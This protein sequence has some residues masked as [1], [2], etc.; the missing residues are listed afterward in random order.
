M[1]EFINNLSAFF[2][3]GS[4][5]QWSIVITVEALALLLLVSRIYYA[6]R[7]YKRIQPK[8]YSATYLLEVMSQ[9]STVPPA[10]AALLLNPHP[11]RVLTTQLEFQATLL[12]LARRGYLNF[13]TD[14]SKGRAGFVINEAK[15]R[16][17]LKTFEK[18]A[19]D[20]LRG[21]SK[22]FAQTGYLDL[23]SFKG[24]LGLHL[25]SF[26]SVWKREP[27]G[28][29]V[30]RFGLPVIRELYKQGQVVG[31]SFVR[32]DSWQ[33]ALRKRNLCRSIGRSFAGLASVASV[34]TWLGPQTINMPSLLA[35]PLTVRVSLV[36]TLSLWGSALFC[37][38]LS[39]LAYKIIPAWQPE[40]VD[41]VWQWRAFRRL[42]A[43]PQGLAKEL[44]GVLERR[45]KLAI[46]ALALGVLPA[47]LRG[48][49]RFAH[50][51]PEL[52]TGPNTT[53]WAD[54]RSVDELV[55]LFQAVQAVVP[56]HPKDADDIQDKSDVPQR[57][58]PSHRSSAAT[59]SSDS[60]A[61]DPNSSGSKS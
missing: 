54:A 19:L 39:N 48:L 4:L 8:T 5:P 29:A 40:I 7:R 45:E 35:T 44:D 18:R 15:S 16:A 24:K 60:K 57:K 25:Y 51:R 55:N 49:K 47:F 53:H 12:D 34:L 14:D 58:T 31:F 10:V 11:E 56:R 21:A 13:Y 3:F 1:R 46:Y 17:H 59:T 26:L 43:R 27:V 22:R 52:V 20:F 9:R 41:Q 28:W 38:W 61:S 30:S 33:D 23:N 6:R 42:L 50:K 37:W 36:S 32:D 2:S